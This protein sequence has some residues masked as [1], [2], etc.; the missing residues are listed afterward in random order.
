MKTLNEL[1]Q[2]VLQRMA[3]EQEREELLAQEKALRQE[4]RL[5]TRQAEE[6]R[7]AEEGLRGITGLLLQLTGKKEERLAQ[8]QRAAAS[9]RA[10]QQ[11]G[12]FRLHTAQDRIAAVDEELEDTWPE[13]QAWLNQMEPYCDADSLAPVKRHALNL[14]QALRLR[15]KIPEQA[16]LLQPLVEKALVYDAYG[17]VRTDLSGGR[18][19]NRAR[20]LREQNRLCQEALDAYVSVVRACASLLPEVLQVEWDGPWTAPEYL[21]EPSTEFRNADMTGRLEN[22]QSWPVRLERALQRND[23]ALN[24]EATKAM[25]ALRQLLLAA[26]EK[27]SH[28]N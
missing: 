26:Q 25:N 10:A 22:V 11:N 27:V 21:L 1:R 4:V 15:R 5:L 18:Y 7:E 9:A 3:L 12:E 8:A 6:A 14:Q 16:A 19:N 28:E 23:E 2:T 24:R 17:D 13:E 20:A